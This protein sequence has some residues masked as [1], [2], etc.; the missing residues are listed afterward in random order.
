MNQPKRRCPQ[1]MQRK[2]PER[3][4]RRT[5]EVRMSQ[6]ER[7]L[8]HQTRAS[9]ARRMSSLIFTMTCPSNVLAGYA[10]AACPGIASLKGD[11]R[12]ASASKSFPPPPSSAHLQKDISYVSPSPHNSMPPLP[13][14]SGSTASAPT[15][16]SRPSPRAAGAE[17]QV[18][19]Q[20]EGQR[21]VLPTT[22][23]EQPLRAGPERLA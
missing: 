3:P 12:D 2:Q 6:P 1:K 20:D 17:D 21:K 23:G 19:Q 16:R 9:Q 14:S 11:S 4:P 15:P 7:R 18:E 22:I 13:V 10:H 8:P 5:W